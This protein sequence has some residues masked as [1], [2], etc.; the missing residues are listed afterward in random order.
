MASSINVRRQIVYANGTVGVFNMQCWIVVVG[1][2]FIALRRF[3]VDSASNFSVDVLQRILSDIGRRRDRK[4]AFGGRGHPFNDDRWRSTEYRCS[5]IRPCQPGKQL[6]WD[7]SQ[8]CGLPVR[9]AHQLPVHCRFLDAFTVDASAR[10]QQ[11]S[12]ASTER[13]REIGVLLHGAVRASCGHRHRRR[14]LATEE[15]TSSPRPSSG[16]SDAA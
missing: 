10:R 11:S 9:R 7:V 6:R 13:R 14:W 1:R 5:N 4:D 3:C 8:R 16:I 12:H 2:Q 15:H